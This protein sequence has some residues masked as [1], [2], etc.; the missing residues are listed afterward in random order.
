L[1]DAMDDRAHE[2]LI[3][4]R[5]GT[6]AR[7][8]GSERAILVGIADGHAE[9]E[10]FRELESLAD[11]AGITTLATVVQNR[12]RPDPATFIGRG[13]VAEVKAAAAELDADAVLFN[14]E[15]SPAQARNLEEAMGRK[16]IDRTQLILDIFAQRAAT[17]EARLQVELAQL[18][19][20]LPRLRG[21]GA[22]LTRAGGRAVGGVGTRG[23]GETQLELD[24]NKINRRIHTLEK[25]LVKATA[26]RG[27][28]RK[29]RMKSD[30]PQVA[31]VG[32]TN[33]GKSTLLNRL[34][35]ADVFV[36]DK[37]FATLDTVVRR[38]AVATG[39]VALFA[40]TVGFIRELPH[41]LVPAF[42]ATLEAAQHA[43]LLIHVVDVARPTWEED[44]RTVLEILEK[45]IFHEQEERPE[46]LNV[47]NKIDLCPNGAPDGIDGV[48]VSALEGLHVD[49]LRERIASAIFPEDRAVAFTFPLHVLHKLSPLT[50]SGR[51][52]IV[53]YTAEAA[54]V[55]ASISMAE[56]E[57]LEREGA[58]L[59]ASG[60]SPAEGS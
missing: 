37:L 10:T 48:A 50:T 34:C 30:I 19:Y 46:A 41:H 33:S 59:I 26:E 4:D 2:P 5:L 47:L 43:D 49:C 29:R 32:Y 3:E 9:E 16:V 60:A 51:A 56:W 35:E 31:L 20:L 58:C 36:E 45:E 21:W 44:H 54:R 25:R 40:D 14:D 15:L 57:L 12:R 22:A 39:R 18:R 13:K 52:Q 17:K 28:R 38:G 11:T 23:P 55:E 8:Y 7:V 42:A 27:V 53:Q 6:R 1:S 24:R